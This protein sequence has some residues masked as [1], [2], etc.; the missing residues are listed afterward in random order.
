ML[1]IKKLFII[2]ALFVNNSNQYMI[3]N[4]VHTLFNNWNCIGIKENIDFSKPYK[5]K[6]GDLPLVVWKD[7]KGN[8]QSAVNIC[9]HM[10]SS[11]DE[12]KIKDGCLTCPYHGLKYT[13]K[14]SIGKT[15]EHEGKIFWSYKPETNKP[16][17]IPYFNNKDY[18]KSYIEIDMECSMTD[19]AYNTMDLKHPTY[20]HSGLIGFGN[21]NPP[22]NIKDHYYKDDKM[23]GLSFDYMSNNIIKTI[24][25]NTKDTRNYHMFKYP[26]FS[27]SRV[28]FKKTNHLLIGVN[29]LPIAEKKT[30]WYIT[31]LHNYLKNNFVEKNFMK[32]MA[33][34]ILLQDQNQMKNQYEENI[35]KKK[36]LFS[37]Q[38][39]DEEP[40]IRLKKLFENYTYP[41]IY[42]CVDLYRDYNKI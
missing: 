14:D 40:I 35:L 38:F 25:K 8:L 23:I 11:F 18:E 3:S 22:K 41:D 20:V 13:E 17:M 16:D 15:I 19:S 29:I 26:A 42:A 33:M 4:K 5:A 30:R 1:N 10:G 32:S 36:I 28:T 39:K 9:K 2:I 21:N 7:N 12:G 34:T 6:I 24:N 27:W 31:I 37:H